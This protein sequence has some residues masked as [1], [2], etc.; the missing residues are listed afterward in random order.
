MQSL[1]QSYTIW[2]NKKYDKNGHLWQGRFKSM[3]VTKNEY[4]LDC[5]NYI[6]LN[7]VRANLVQNPSEYIWSSY[8]SRIL[9]VG[10][11]LLDMPNII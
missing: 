11:E 2:F 7:P 9:G 10:N 5:I 8:A 4:L 3:V 1:N 6:E